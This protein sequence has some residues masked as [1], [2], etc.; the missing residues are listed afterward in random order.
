M[1]KGADLIIENAI[2]DAMLPAPGETVVAGISGGADSLSLLLLLLEAAA[3]HG[4]KVEAVHI[5]HGIRGAAADADEEFVK[6]LAKNC[7]FTAFHENVPA[8]AKEKGLTEE[9]AG[10]IIRYTRFAEVCRKTG[11]KRLYV[12]HNM[13]D[14]AETLLFN[15][16]RGSSLAGL[17]GIKKQSPFPEGIAEV[18]GLVICRPLLD[19][20]RAEIENYLLARGQSWCEDATNKSGIYSRNR[21]RKLL[22]ELGSLNAAAVKHIYETA[23]DIADAEEYLGAETAKHYENLV[24]DGT[25]ELTGFCAL[26]ELIKK[27]IVYR[28]ICEA[29]G[30]RKDIERKHVESVL[31]LA[32]G[33]T[34]KNADLPYGISCIKEYDRLRF[35]MRSENERGKN[36]MMKYENDETDFSINQLIQTY[37]IQE[38]LKDIYEVQ[39]LGEIGISE[40]EKPEDEQVMGSIAPLCDPKHEYRVR[41]YP[42]EEGMII[43]GS[44][45]KVYFDLEKLI[46]HCVSPLVFR[47]ALEGDWFSPF[48]T[49]GK[50]NVARF[51]IDEKVT[52]EEREKAV[53]L[54]SGDRAL[55]ICGM[56]NDEGFRVNDETENIIEIERVEV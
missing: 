51:F 4:F 18:E 41:I 3:K 14:V 37:K 21:I 8:Y 26:P 44:K 6:K 50:K 36:D 20:S 33:E 53:L 35:K 15:L 49:G 48:T 1:R 46:S 2:S 34:G 17:G 45:D 19:F 9:E 42:A 22:S 29:C 7:G 43:K 54:C 27:R 56:R 12:A 39:N 52:K 55:W 10:R 25:L 38:S 5:N 24:K 40:D 11:A 47:F 16:T 32:A 13:N 28:L 30:R 31:S 23:E